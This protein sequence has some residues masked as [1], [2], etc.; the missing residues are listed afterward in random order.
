MAAQFVDFR[1]K[2]SGRSHDGIG[3]QARGDD[4][5]FRQA[6]R[7]KQPGECIAAR[8]LGAVDERQPFLGGELDGLKPR[9]LQ[10]IGTRHDFAAELRL[11]LA[12]HHRRHVGKRRKVARRT[13][14]ALVRHHRRHAFCQ[15]VLYLLDHQPAHPRC[16]PAQREQFQSHHEPGDVGGHGIAH[17]CA[18]RQD[19]VALKRCGVIGLDLHRGQFAETGI[20]AIDRLAAL[21]SR[22][23]LRRRALNGWPGSVVKLCGKTGAI[24]LPELVER[25]CAGG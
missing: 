2:R 1:L 18:M 24:D 10:G 16:A 7:L 13:D 3:R 19:Q 15:H 6:A 23:D 22:R 8:E 21:C 14:R 4:G 20:D 5:G 25:C 12:Q 17:T 9:R 11:A